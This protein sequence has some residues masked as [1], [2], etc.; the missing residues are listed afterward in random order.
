MIQC[1]DTSGRVILWIYTAKYGKNRFKM[2]YHYRRPPPERRSVVAHWLHYIWAT[3]DCLSGGGLKPLPERQSEV[4]YAYGSLSRPLPERRSAV[5]FIN[6]VLT[7][8]S[9]NLKSVFF[10]IFLVLPYFRGRGYVYTF[11]TDV[12]NRKHMFN[13]IYR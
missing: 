11:I 4:A 12:F 9:V 1:Q 2:E 8:V 3:S 13:V 7:F 5:A 6:F 10:S